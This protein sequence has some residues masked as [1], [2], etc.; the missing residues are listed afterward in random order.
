[1]AV[2]IAFLA[3]PDAPTRIVQPGDITQGDTAAVTVPL[4]R[5]GDIIEQQIVKKQFTYKVKG[6]TD[7]EV[8]SL[9]SLADTNLT[10]LVAG[11]NPTV[12][13]ITYSGLTFSQ[14]FLRSVKPS[15]GVTIGNNVI[16][17]ST[18]LLYE[19]LDRWLA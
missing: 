3:V 8:A 9:K 13:A 7:V 10:N 19:T 4:N 17:D 18:D 6:L 5:N 14:C 12:K 11:T 2:T 16:V 15:G 1:M